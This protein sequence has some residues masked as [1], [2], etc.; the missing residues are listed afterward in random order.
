[1]TFVRKIPRR[2]L[3]GE[4]VRISVETR[5]SPVDLVYTALDGKAEVWGRSCFQCSPAASAGPCNP[6]PAE[7][8]C[9]PATRPNPPSARCDRPAA[10]TSHANRSSPRPKRP[11]RSNSSSPASCATAATTAA[12]RS[13]GSLPSP[14]SMSGPPRDSAP[15]TRGAVYRVLAAHRSCSPSGR[16]WPVCDQPILDTARASGQPRC[17]ACGSDS[18]GSTRPSRRVFAPLSPVPSRRRVCRVAA[19]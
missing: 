4:H 11:T 10:N 18:A 7:I 19:R 14:P 13:S 8:S 16:R 1:M 15:S 2:T 17:V 9:P 3:R 12:D 6:L 5:G